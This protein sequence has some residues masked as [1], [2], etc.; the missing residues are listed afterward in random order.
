MFTCQKSFMNKF[1]QR[2]NESSNA[3]FYIATR[4]VW[5]RMTT[6]LRKLVW[7]HHKLTLYWQEQQKKGNITKNE[8]SSWT[9]AHRGYLLRRC[10]HA[11]SHPSWQERECA[12]IYWNSGSWCGWGTNPA[13]TIT[14]YVGSMW[15]MTYPNVHHYTWSS[16]LLQGPAGGIDL[17]PGATTAHTCTDLGN[18]PA[19]CNALSTHCHH[20]K[21]TVLQYFFPQSLIFFTFLTTTLWNR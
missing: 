8:M 2:Q 3:S 1:F 5:C 4:R 7:T 18:E 13:Q 10:D 14:L 12:V 11:L 20:L 21:V 6:W 16:N 19:E 15:M 9:S 17:C